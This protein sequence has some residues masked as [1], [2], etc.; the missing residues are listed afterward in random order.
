MRRMRSLAMA[1]AA[2]IMAACPQVRAESSGMPM[3][4][5]SAIRHIEVDKP[6]LRPVAYTAFCLRYESG[7]RTTHL[8]RGGPLPLTKARWADLKAINLSVNRSIA[9]DRNQRHSRWIHGSSIP[10]GAIAATTPSANDTSLSNAACLR[11]RSCLARSK[12]ARTS[13]TWFWSCGQN[14]GIW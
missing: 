10:P 7:C 3:V 1:A 4:P 5:P 6:T 9:P 8:F 11:E 12:P 14:S 2:V 13:I